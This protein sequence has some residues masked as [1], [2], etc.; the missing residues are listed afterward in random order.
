MYAKAAKEGENVVDARGEV[1][2][3]PKLY[4]TSKGIRLMK[5]EGCEAKRRQVCMITGRNEQSDFSSIRG[6][7][8]RVSDLIAVPVFGKLAQAWSDVKRP[9]QT[10]SQYIDS[11][12]VKVNI[13]SYET[14]LAIQIDDLRKVSEAVCTTSDFTKKAIEEEEDEV[15]ESDVLESLS[16]L[17][18]KCFECSQVKSI[19]NVITC[20]ID[21]GVIWLEPHTW[22]RKVINDAYPFVEQVGKQK[23]N[24]DL[25]SAIDVINKSKLCSGQNHI[26]RRLVI[27]H[28][29]KSMLSM[30]HGGSNSLVTGALFAVL[31][32]YSCKD[33]TFE[34]M[35]NLNVARICQN[36]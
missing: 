36:C 30:L 20:T 16:Y 23:A 24:I 32:A 6:E 34:H 2:I 12:K 4:I 31:N 14:I 28:L 9:M 26:E 3:R 13:S 35:L 5:I 15:V 7:N 1:N 10:K 11:C 33:K 27:T 22:V 18:T 21:E 8:K 29:I 25:Y 17:N 19:E